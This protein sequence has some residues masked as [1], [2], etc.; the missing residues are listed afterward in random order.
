VELRKKYKVDMVLFVINRSLLADQDESR[1]I[2]GKADTLTGSGIVSVSMFIDENE[3]NRN[4]IQHITMHETFHLLG[5]LHD[6]WGRRCV[7]NTADNKEET[8]LNYFYEFQLPIRLW[9]Y[10]Y[11]IGRSFPE[12]AFVTA[13]SNFLLWIP[14][15]IG[16]ELVLHKAYQKA[17]ILDASKNHR[18]CKDKTFQKNKGLPMRW[19]LPSLLAC[20]VLMGTSFDS[21]FFMVAP[22]SLMAFIHHYYYTREKIKNEPWLKFTDDGEEEDDGKGHFL[23]M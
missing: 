19:F 20:A 22:L 5:Y 7:M 21:I 8:R 14:Y 18:I 23:Y 12:A 2:G 16:V 15:F 3:Y 17:M 11:G 6:R 4:R 13:F 10:K 9:T 1:A